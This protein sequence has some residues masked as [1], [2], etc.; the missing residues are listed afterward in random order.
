M[1]P[2]ARPPADAE[3]DSKPHVRI[4]LERWLL[5]VSFVV[6]ALIFGGSVFTS[7]GSL[8]PPV[9]TEPESPSQQPSYFSLDNHRLTGDEFRAHARE[10]DHDLVRRVRDRDPDPKSLPS[11]HDA[12][13]K[14]KQNVESIE[15]QLEAAGRAPPGTVLWGRR[16]ELERLREDAPPEY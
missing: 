3:S 11:R 9:E 1:N 5:G 8:A 16:Q 6:S 12:R 10:L 14:W 2:D 7:F 4:S 13:R 15:S